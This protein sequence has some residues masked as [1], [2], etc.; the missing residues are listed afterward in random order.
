LAKA[1]VVVDKIIDC[2][3][4]NQGTE[5]SDLTKLTGLDS[6]KVRVLL[7]FLEKFNF[8]YIDHQDGKVKLTD[9]SMKTIAPQR[10]S[11]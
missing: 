6:D 7:D 11:R 2:L 3:N 4:D 1:A 8:I 9:L 5:I 10:P